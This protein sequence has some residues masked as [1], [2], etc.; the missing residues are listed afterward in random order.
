MT[1]R[2]HLQML[3]LS[4]VILLSFSVNYINHFLHLAAGPE[5]YHS[6]ICICWIHEQVNQV[7]HELIQVAWIQGTSW[8]LA[9]RTSSTSTCQAGSFF[10]FPSP[11]IHTTSCLS[12]SPVCLSVLQLSN[13]LVPDLMI[14]DEKRVSTCFGTGK[15]AGLGTPHVALLQQILIAVFALYCIVL[16]H[17]LLFALCDT[18][19]TEVKWLCGEAVSLAPPP[20]FPTSPAVLTDISDRQHLCHIRVLVWTSLSIL[21]G[22]SLF[23]TWKYNWHV[24]IHKML[25]SPTACFQPLEIT[26]WYC[27][28]VLLYFACTCM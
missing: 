6:C 21:E 7:S 8:V 27:Y 26:Y 4:P 14:S 10:F 5:I 25:I 24:D 17:G 13:Y 20:P 15:W 23:S 12:S 19:S 11:I 18:F 9:K 1:I 16:L 28:P 2:H 22:W 3:Q